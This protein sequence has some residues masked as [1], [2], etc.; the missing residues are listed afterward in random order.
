[1]KAASYQLFAFLFAFFFF[2][3][4]FIVVRYCEYELQFSDILL[5]LSPQMESAPLG[6][7]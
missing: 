5:S 6:T 1:M 7:S 3:V 4:L 2:V